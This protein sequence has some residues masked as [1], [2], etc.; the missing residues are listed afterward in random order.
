MVIADVDD[1]D[2]E[3]VLVGA[4]LVEYV[5]V[6]SSPDPLATASTIPMTMT[7]RRAPEQPTAASMG[8]LVPD[9]ARGGR[10]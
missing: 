9:A 5:G 1:V 10:G 4:V 3:N 8:P 2:G 6:G 7:S